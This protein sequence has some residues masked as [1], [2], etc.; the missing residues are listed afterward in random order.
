MNTDIKDI[1]D[2]DYQGEEIKLDKI[3]HLKY[4]VKGLKIL[5]KE[6][7]SVTE[8]MA[9]LEQLNPAIDDETISN[10]VIFAYAGLLHEDKSITLDQIENM[11]DFNTLLEVM[12]TVPYAVLHSMPK[13]DEVSQDNQGKQKLTSTALSISPG[14]NGNSRKKKQIV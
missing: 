12:K 6:F 9:K 1:N 8:A 13:P 2:F 4:T 14:S 10:I 11:L 5:S 7:G 3:R